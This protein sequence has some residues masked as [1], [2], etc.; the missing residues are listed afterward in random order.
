MF[1]AIHTPVYILTLPA[2]AAVAAVA[3]VATRPLLLLPQEESSEYTSDDESE[4]EGG[5]KLVKP[6]FVRRTERDVS[7]ACHCCPLCL[8]GCL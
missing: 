8:D 7:S 6:V 1:A 5:R 2:A 4:E 3:A